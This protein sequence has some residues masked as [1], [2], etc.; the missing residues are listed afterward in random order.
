MKA[1]DVMTSPV[2]TIGPSHSAKELAQIFL[3]RRISAVPVVDHDGKLVGIVSE[4]DL[5]RRSETDTERHRSWWLMLFT[6]SQTLAADYIQA[7]ARKVSDLMT[8][9]VI[10]ATSDTTLE[11]I[12]TLLETNE[13]KRVPILANGQLVGIVSRANL[14][15][16]MASARPGLDIPMS[17]SV[18]RDRLMAHLKAQPWAHLSLVNVTVFGGVVSLWGIV[19]S[20]V[21]KRAL[22][23]AAEQTT[24]V[25]TV[26]DNLTIA[27]AVL[28]AA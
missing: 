14:I 18:I 25:R 24:G 9:N 2:V 22:R 27:A 6:D 8:K 28:G 11:E 23:V 19:P 17:D 21:E 7:H 3:R 15:Q 26:N 5:M 12:A 13:I 10:T 1:R 16:A 4:G 20:D